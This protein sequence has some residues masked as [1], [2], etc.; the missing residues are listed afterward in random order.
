[1]AASAPVPQTGYRARL[2]DSPVALVEDLRRESHP[3]K[4]P[5]GF[6][7]DF[8]I[9]LPYRGLFVWHVGRDDV[10]GD[11]NQIVF[12][13]AGEPYRVSAPAAEGYAEL[14]VTPNLDLLYEISHTHGARLS[15]HPL[16][17]Q[18]AC[19]ASSSLHV[20]RARLLHSARANGGLETEELVLALVRTT[21]EGDTRRRT[22][23]SSQTLRL[24]RRAKEFL[25]VEFANPLRL[26][27]IARA[28][29]ASPAYLTDV[30]RRIEGVPLHQYLT[31]LRLARALVELPE[32]GDLTKLA[33]DVGFSSHSHFSAAFRKAFAC[34]P[35][36]LREC[37]RRR[38]P[39]AQ[40]FS[41]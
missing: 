12:V 5:L 25:A 23:Y 2:L 24:I 6:C 36:Q 1:M 29:G 38:H 26:A 35:S 7:A 32:N 16:F 34:T 28:A 11:P 41:A 17:R 37:A 27:D 18:R 33:L 10:V 15:D 13:R 8:Q 30:F 39:H 21:L 22:G 20:L 4:G 9:C 3:E 14:I 19:L 31:H 40:E